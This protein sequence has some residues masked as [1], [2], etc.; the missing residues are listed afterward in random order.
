MVSG[1]A[2][3]R[4]VG[5]AVLKRA[6]QTCLC[7]SPELLRVP[8]ALCTQRLTH[9]RPRCCRLHPRPSPRGPTAQRLEVGRRGSSQD[10]TRCGFTRPGRKINHHRR[11][12]QAPRELSRCSSRVPLHKPPASPSAVWGW[13]PTPK[14]R[15]HGH[16]ETFR[17][18]RG[19]QQG[20]GLVCSLAVWLQ[21]PRLPRLIMSL[22]SAGSWGTRCQTCLA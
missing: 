21:A 17:E 18:R 7:H 13:S 2:F 12:Y 16:R 19:G 4:P 1:L 10:G 9:A 11:R 5:A 22:G 15:R 6:F 8:P 3:Q 20:R 14:V